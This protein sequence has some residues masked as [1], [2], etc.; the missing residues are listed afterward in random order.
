[1]K[2]DVA[3]DVESRPINLQQVRVEIWHYDLNKSDNELQLT[4]LT[5]A[6]ASHE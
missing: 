6:V 4:M 1:M 2:Q 5:E 3:D